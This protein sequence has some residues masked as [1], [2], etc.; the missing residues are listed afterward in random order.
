MVTIGLAPLKNG[1]IN[2]HF[3]AHTGL[4]PFKWDIS[5]VYCYNKRTLVSVRQYKYHN[6]VNAHFCFVQFSLCM[7]MKWNAKGR[8]KYARQITYFDVQNLNKVVEDFVLSG[9]FMVEFIIIKCVIRS[10]FMATFTLSS[11][12]VSYVR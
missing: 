3:I 1:T 11:P 8:A 6:F 2:S 9:S 5:M 10:C 12:A 4:T 7:I